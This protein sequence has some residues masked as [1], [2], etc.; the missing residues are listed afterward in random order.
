MESNTQVMFLREYLNARKD[1][2]IFTDSRTRWFG[3][4]LLVALENGEQILGYNKKPLYLYTAVVDSHP[5]IGGELYKYEGPGKPWGERVL[6]C[7]Y[8]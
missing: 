6:Y 2:T 3:R 8:V 5:L 7:S 1:K 4:D